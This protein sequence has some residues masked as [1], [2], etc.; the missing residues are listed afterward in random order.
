[1]A[2]ELE[3]PMMTGETNRLGCVGQLGETGDEAQVI[4]EGKDGRSLRR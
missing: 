2:M 4:G 3:F 1:M